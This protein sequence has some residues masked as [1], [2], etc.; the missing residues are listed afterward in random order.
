MMLIREIIK[1]FEEIVP[2]QIE[3]E[4]DNSGFQL[5][6]AGREVEKILIC[7]ELT[8]AV[9]EEAKEINASLIF[10][11]HPFIFHSIKTINLRSA[12]GSII[13]KLIK[14]DIS[15][16]SAHTN[17]DQYKNGISYALG[18]KLNLKEMRPLVVE[19]E[20][21]YKITA[22][23]P[24]ESADKVALALSE[25]GAGN[26]GNY[27]ECSFQSP[28]EGS[29][30]GS[31]ESN[32]YLG[33]KGEKEKVKEIK[34]EM[35]FPKW[36]E[37]GIVKAL[38]LSH[39]YEEPAFDII[40]LKNK[41]PEFGYGVTG[42]LEHETPAKEFLTLLKKTL[43][44]PFIKCAGNLNKNVKRISLLGGS[45]GNYINTAIKEGSDIFITADLSYHMF[46]NADEKIIIADAGHY[47]TE[48]FGLTELQ[49]LLEQL[50]SP[51]V[52]IIKTKNITNPIIYF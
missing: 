36:K 41:I 51:E 2:K 21:Y 52:I 24:E 18:N 4:K 45:G 7:L 49:R 14:S 12:L 37:S 27:S 8:E 20:H 31:T 26:I 48:I 10:T 50:F 42:E 15:V 9:V 6:D 22:F 44:I 47:E 34:L 5:G 35:I 1:K 38:R 17:F 28:G 23:V 33:T 40:P 29:F 13:E 46:F 39:P 43:N 19:G 16:Y 32:P 3:W 30:R 25:A 11:H